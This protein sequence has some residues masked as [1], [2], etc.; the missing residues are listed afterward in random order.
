MGCCGWTCDAVA[1]GEGLK[2]PQ[3]DAM[4][5]EITR[6]LSAD[7]DIFRTPSSTGSTGS[8]GNTSS[9]SSPKHCVFAC[10]APGSISGVAAVDVL[11]YLP[12]QWRAMGLGCAAPVARSDA[13]ATACDSVTYLGGD[14]SAAGG[15]Q[16]ILEKILR[17]L[18]LA[19]TGAVGAVGRGAGEA[20]VMTHG[21]I[22]VVVDD[23]GLSSRATMR[24]VGLAMQ[25]VSLAFGDDS[26]AVTVQPFFTSAVLRG[27]SGCHV[28]TAAAL[29]MQI[30]NKLV[31]IDDR[32]SPLTARADDSM[33]AKC[34]TATL[35]SSARVGGSR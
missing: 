21:V 14:Q 16:A 24:M 27:G 35:F 30:Y 7:I 10:I 12:S 15:A 34:E 20:V 19:C 22:V 32:P 26:L 6:T 9:S 2:L 29:A 13:G 33:L 4:G 18:K 17:S 11:Q 5:G 1:G 25:A 28:D 3:Q 23:V 31:L 8:A